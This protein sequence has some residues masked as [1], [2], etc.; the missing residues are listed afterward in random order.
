[1][2]INGTYKTQHGELSI[3]QNGDNITATYQENGVCSG[4]LIGN[5]VEGIW[6]NKKDQGLFEWIFDDKGNFSGKYKSGIEKGPMRGKWT[7]TNNKLV[8]ET[9]SFSLNLDTSINQI[10]RFVDNLVHSEDEEMIAFVKAVISF[11]NDNNE[12][13]WWI[14]AIKSHL[15]TWQNR[16]DDEELDIS[17]SSLSING[18]DLDFNPNDSFRLF[19]NTR[20]RLFSVDEDDD[21]PNSFFEAVIYMDG[22]YSSPEELI[23]ICND[24]D[25]TNYLKF[26]NKCKTVLYCTI[27]KACEDGIDAEDLSELL[28]GVNFYE[29]LSDINDEIYGG[30]IC[31]EIQE[32]VLTSF[33]LNRSDF[34]D[35]ENLW[36]DQFVTN[37]EDIAQVLIDNEVF[38]NDYIS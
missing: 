35:D 17:I 3:A 28:L 31:N 38:D 6:K 9:I 25:Q 26:I 15:Q 24:T 11:I 2:N 19:Y 12:Y 23:T 10:F 32:D 5:K 21:E 29:R 8:T 20:E 1:M 18:V 37:W 36:K 14:P 13:Y 16:I 30:D 22:S 33:N 7:G 4:K 34:D 27:C